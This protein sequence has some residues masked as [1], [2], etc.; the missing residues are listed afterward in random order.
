MQGSRTKTRHFLLLVFL[1]AGASSVQG[2][3]PETNW[4]TKPAERAVLNNAFA[5]AAILYQG[6]LAL[7]PADPGLLWRL[8]EVYTMGGQFSLAQETYGE[9]LKVGKDAARITRAI[10]RVASKAG[11]PQ[12][13]IRSPIWVMRPGIPATS[14]YPLAP[15]T[16]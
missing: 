9:W 15:G 8:A 4:L 11:G 10:C 12:A 16:A 13:S 3:A 5:Q 7:R 2:T 14:S 6:A 1:L